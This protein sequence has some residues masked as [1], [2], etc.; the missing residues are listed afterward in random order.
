MTPLWRTA[1]WGY[2]RFH[3]G[4]AQPPPRYGRQAL[5]SWAGRIADAWPDQDD[6]YVYFNNDLGGAAVV[7][8]A[9]FARAAATLGRT[10]SRTPSSLSGLGWPGAVLYGRPV[11][12]EREHALRGVRDARAEAG[13]DPAQPLPKPPAVLL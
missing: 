12:A 11:D 5:K 7:D 10:V 8:A 3:G 13:T 6:V 2:V 4:I 1:S 9:R